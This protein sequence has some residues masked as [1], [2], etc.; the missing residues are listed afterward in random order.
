MVVSQAAGRRRSPPSVAAYAAALG[1]PVVFALLGAGRP[2]L[3]AA[4]EAVLRRLGRDRARLAVVDRRDPTPRA[5]GRCLRGL[6]C[7]GT[8]CDEAML[9]AARRSARSGA[10]SR[11]PELALGPTVDADG[12]T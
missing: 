11:C 1:T 12:H 4:A 7:G 5:P 8:L 2:D 10:T 3:T 6:F 9:I